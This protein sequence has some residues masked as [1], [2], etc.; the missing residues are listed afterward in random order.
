[1]VLIIEYYSKEE[2]K[3]D[4]CVYI[5]IC[6]LVF[7]NFVVLESKSMFIINLIGNKL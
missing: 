3:C 4:N 1:M 6:F 5:R 2:R 7:G